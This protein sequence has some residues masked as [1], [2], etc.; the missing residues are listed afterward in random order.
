ML[1]TAH[2][3]NEISVRHPYL[4]SIRKEDIDPKDCTLEKII[5]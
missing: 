3:D 5:S 2:G 4:K 1:S